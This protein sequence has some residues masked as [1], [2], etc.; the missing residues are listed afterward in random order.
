[1]PRP[2]HLPLPPDGSSYQDQLEV[3]GGC[4]VN[5]QE[6]YVPT[7]VY[8]GLNELLATRMRIDK[9]TAPSVR[10]PP[11]DYVKGGD[12]FPAGARVVTEEDRERFLAGTGGDKPIL[13]SQ[14][15][16]RVIQRYE[17]DQRSAG[18]AQK[19]AVKSAAVSS[20]T[21]MPAATAV[22]SGTLAS[23]LKSYKRPKLDVGE[24]KVQFVKKPPQLRSTVTSETISVRS[25]QFDDGAAA[26][27]SSNSRREEAMDS[28]E[29]I[30]QS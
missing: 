26:T 6:L 10:V 4:T 3:Y 29:E 8:H 9:V 21:A 25:V 19:T 28:T 20:V 27:D 12:P 14:L 17:R 22:T 1:M 24:D 5:L 11:G 30:A 15:A 7:V 23:A 2:L 13:I 16:R 18:G